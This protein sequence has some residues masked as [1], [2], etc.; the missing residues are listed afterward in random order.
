LINDDAMRPLRI[1]QRCR[2]PLR[3]VVVLVA[4]SASQA[5]AS[6]NADARIVLHAQP[7]NIQNTC[8]TPQQSTGLDCD[9]VR[10][11]VNVSAG[12]AIDVYVYLHSYDSIAGAQMAFTW[13]ASWTFQYWVG[14]C[15]A[16]ELVAV[17]T[18]QASGDSYIGAFDVI[19]GG[20]LQPLGRLRFTTGTSGTQ[21]TVTETWAPGGTGVI[22]GQLDFST[23]PSNHRGVIAVGT[24]GIDACGGKSDSS[25]LYEE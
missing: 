4:L 21:F 15:Q 20:A 18:P 5:G 13:P 12:Q 24:S 14:A 23:I 2:H 16:H 19:T 3:W 6:Q 22:D 8:T 9:S 17:G 25:A 7:F 1:L 11:T 10:P